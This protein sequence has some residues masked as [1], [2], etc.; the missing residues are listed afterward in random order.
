MRQLAPCDSF[1]YII[2]YK[3]NEKA[4]SD[5]ADLL[6]T[7]DDESK[8]LAANLPVEQL[9]YTLYTMRNGFLFD[10]KAKTILKLDYNV[11]PP[12]SQQQGGI[13]LQIHPRNVSR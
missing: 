5:K 9:Y 3:V 7:L 10:R 8:Q 13:T 2:N 6:L 12:Q 1:L 4:H 11:L